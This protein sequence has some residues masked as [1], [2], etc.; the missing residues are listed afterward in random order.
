[1][2]SYILMALSYSILYSKQYFSFSLQSNV[3]QQALKRKLQE[4]K[5]VTK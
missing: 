5:M 3:P 4:E 2:K 1:M